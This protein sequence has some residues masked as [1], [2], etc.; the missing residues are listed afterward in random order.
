MGCARLR[1][2][3]HWFISGITGILGSNEA[4]YTSASINF[5]KIRNQQQ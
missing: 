2:G 4:N 1:T 3:I 5:A